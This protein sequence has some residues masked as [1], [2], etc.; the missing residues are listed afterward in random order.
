MC[1]GPICITAFCDRLEA[2]K[3]FLSSA[4]H[5]RLLPT[6]LFLPLQLDDITGLLHAPA[7]F[8]FVNGEG[9]FDTHTMGGWVG[10]AQTLL[11]F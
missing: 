6:T 1:G 8:S 9:A 11:V 10:P 5:T 2:A 4:I 7:S 3:P